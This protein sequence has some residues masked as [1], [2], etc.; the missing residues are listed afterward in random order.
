ML[1]EGKVTWSLKL[2]FCFTSF[3]SSTINFVKLSIF[4]NVTFPSSSPFQ[5]RIINRDHRLN[6]N[7]CKCLLPLLVYVPHFSFLLVSKHK[8][9]ALV[10]ITTLLFLWI[11]RLLCWRCCAATS[12]EPRAITSLNFKCACCIWSAR[13][14][15][16]EPTVLCKFSSHFSRIAS[17]PS[18]WIIFPRKEKKMCRTLRRAWNVVKSGSAVIITCFSACQHFDVD[19]GFTAMLQIYYAQWIITTWFITILIS[20]E[21]DE[22]WRNENKKTTLISC[23]CLTN[24][25]VETMIYDLE[26]W[27]HS[28]FEVQLIIKHASRQAMMNCQI[29]IDNN[30]TFS[31]FASAPDL[32]DCIRRS[33]LR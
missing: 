19:A 5:Y 8:S 29:Y 32:L 23:A 26:R 7:Q 16:A 4:H 1:C 13:K 33:A 12:I 3:N 9:A 10:C 27:F 21:T 17:W 6:G 25:M 22:K 28:L 2:K 14:F 11:Y 31:L 24:D 30:K 18:D 20:C 15:D